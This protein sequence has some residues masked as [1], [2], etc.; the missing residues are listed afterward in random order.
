MIGHFGFWPYKKSQA[1]KTI[2][3]EVMTDTEMKLLHQQISDYEAVL[4]WY[5]DCTYASYRIDGGDK[6]RAVIEKYRGEK[7]NAP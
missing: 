1:R 7:G 6:A 5:G 3:G 2:I 4:Q